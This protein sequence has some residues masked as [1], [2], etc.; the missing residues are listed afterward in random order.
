MKLSNSIT[1][2]AAVGHLARAEPVIQRVKDAA[3]A[4]LVKRRWTRVR[5]EIARRCAQVLEASAYKA[6]GVGYVR[7]FYLICFRL[8]AHG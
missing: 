5:K 8:S 3:F 6:Y 7:L 1:G 4:Y 2:S